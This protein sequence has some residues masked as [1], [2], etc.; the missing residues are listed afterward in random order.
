MN[1]FLLDE[2]AS[3]KERSKP[4][5]TIPIAI[6]VE[7]KVLITVGDITPYKEMFEA[8]S[9]DTDSTI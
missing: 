7:G 1:S 4:S 9:Q 6:D 5:Q 2:I 8:D 3:F